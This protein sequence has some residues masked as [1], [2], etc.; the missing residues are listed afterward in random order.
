MGK[1]ANLTIKIL[2]A[3][4][5]GALTAVEVI[6]VLTMTDE[7]TQNIFGSVAEA[8]V[9]R[10]QRRKRYMRYMNMLSYI[11]KNELISARKVGDVIRYSLT[12]DG[13][14][15]RDVLRA[16]NTRRAI[17]A[18]YEAKP[19]KKLIVIAYDIPEKLRKQRE[20][21]RAVL[22]RLGFQKLQ[23]SVWIG[24]FLLPKEFI[25]DLLKFSIE[26]Y[27]EIIEVGSSGTTRELL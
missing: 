15:R 24:K 10:V 20:W 22:K 13:R 6:G 23:N 1:P 27:V 21:L 18:S 8:R 3:L 4:S 25:N 2:D 17:G 7:F 16:E 26:E 5:D 11:K 12:A 19:G 14:R 9:L